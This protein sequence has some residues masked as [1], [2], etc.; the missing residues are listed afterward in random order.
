MN[1]AILFLIV[2]ISV[3]GCDR[4][5]K[6]NKP[7]VVAKASDAVL[8][9]N[10]IPVN[11]I[12]GT[13]GPDSMA[14]IQNYINKWAKREFIYQ[15]AKENLSPDLRNEIER[16][17][18]ETRADLIIYQY[19]RQMML[20]RM[21]TVVTD[22]E[23]ESHYNLNPG[24]FILSSNIVKALFIKLPLETPNLNRIRLLSRSNNQSDL[25]ELE[26]NCFQFAEKFDD[27][28]ENWITMDRLA[29][30]LGDRINDQ[31]GFLKRNTFY[32][33]T[34]SVS[35]Y[36]LNIRDYRL[37]SAIAPFEYVREDI[38]RIILNNRRFEFIQTLEN[39]IFND[40]IKQNKL[41]IY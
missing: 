3:I 12:M 24:S 8:L 11:I 10:Q 30:E 13:G 40:A 18:S 31:E 35:V 26:S 9:Y 36:L 39:G 21:D 16:Q 17:I 33:M 34:D 7:V 41:K 28:G 22:T 29:L 38:K 14:I 5:R 23:I 15:K 20:E 27:F 2:A 1:K 37:R 25:Q 6:D 32:E 19:Q 4:F